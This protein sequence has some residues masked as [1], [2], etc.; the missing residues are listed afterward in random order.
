MYFGAKN[1]EEVSI[2]PPVFPPLHGAVYGQF[3]VAP[4]QTT[5]YTLTVTGKKGRKAQRQLT[6]EVPPG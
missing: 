2:D 3:Y 1:P 6:I 5:T 4:A